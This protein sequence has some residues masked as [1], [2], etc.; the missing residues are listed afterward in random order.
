MLGCLLS[1][2]S[3]RRQPLLEQVKHWRVAPWLR[4]LS[5]R[6]TPP[7]GPRLRTLEGHTVW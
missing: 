5:S 6:L 4:P 2:E 7:G 3:P 1:L